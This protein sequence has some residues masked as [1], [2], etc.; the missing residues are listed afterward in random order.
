M[1]SQ[2]N[3]AIYQGDDYA[4]VVTVSNGSTAPPDLTGYTAESQIRVGPAMYN[5]TVVVQIDTEVAP[6]N[7]INL[8]IPNGITLQL[9]GQYVWDLQL[10]DPTGIKTTI[11]AGNVL[12]TP[13]V[14]RNAP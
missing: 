14:T 10:T 13:D 11:L 1:P 7:T 2:A 3:L 8:S 6:P 4:A 9:S 12:V 5:P